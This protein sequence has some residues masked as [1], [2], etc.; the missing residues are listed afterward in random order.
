MMAFEPRGHVRLVR[1]IRDT[2]LEHCAE[3]WRLCRSPD[4]APTTTLLD[5]EQFVKR[6]VA[7]FVH[8]ALMHGDLPSIQLGSNGELSENPAEH[9][10]ID[11]AENEL[12][13]VRDY[14]SPFTGTIFV[15]EAA[16]RKLFE[17]ALAPGSGIQTAADEN[18]LADWLAVR[19][20]AAPTDP[21]VKKI[22]EMQ[23]KEEGFRFSGERFKRAWATAV[24]H[25]GAHAWGEP[26]RRKSKGPIKGQI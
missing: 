23:A 6:Q 26:G 15:E 4:V 20:R 24:K 8:E 21:A 22:V 19:M 16:L 9:W 7:A 5:Q 13:G 12:C 1:A 2:A 25:A 3:V 17:K 10:R 14:R 11:G 18:R